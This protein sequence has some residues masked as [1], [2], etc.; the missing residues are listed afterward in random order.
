[1]DRELKFGLDELKWNSN[2]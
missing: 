2:D 1:M